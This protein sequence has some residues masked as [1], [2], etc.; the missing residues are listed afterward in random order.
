MVRK[1]Q[2]EIEALQ[3]P[4]KETYNFEIKLGAPEFPE[5]EKREKIP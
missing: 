5:L 4:L 3:A 2:G 1:L